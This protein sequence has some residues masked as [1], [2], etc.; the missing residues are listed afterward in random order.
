MSLCEKIKKTLEKHPYHVIENMS[1]NLGTT[2]Y[3]PQT[4]INTVE[5]TKNET[6]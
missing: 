3:L 4:R 1:P 2:F 6:K 5:L